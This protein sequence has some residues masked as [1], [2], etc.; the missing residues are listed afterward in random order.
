MKI[1]IINMSK[2]GSS[3]QI[4]ELKDISK[5]ELQPN[6]LLSGMYYVAVLDVL[7]IRVYDLQAYETIIE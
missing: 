5:L 2:K 3:R 1:E 4:V 6:V 7:R